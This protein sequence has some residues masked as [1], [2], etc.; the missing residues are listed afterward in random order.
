MDRNF[1]VAV[2]VEESNGGKTLN[3]LIAEMQSHTKHFKSFNFALNI[4]K[5]KRRISPVDAETRKFSFK[6]IKIYDASKINPFLNIPEN[7]LDVSYR[8]DLTD[9][10]SVSVRDFQ[11]EMV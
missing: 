11:G 8:L 3:K 5:E 7:V 2:L 10:P 4:E 6:S 9:V 1:L